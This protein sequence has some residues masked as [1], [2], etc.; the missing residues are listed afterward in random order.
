MQLFLH[1]DIQVQEKHIQC[2]E[3]IKINFQ[4]NR[5]IHKITIFNYK[6][7]T[8]SNKLNNLR[9]LL[10]DELMIYLNKK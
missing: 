8:I 6:K 9:E 5:N 4:I 1:M 10:S 2:K 3:I 7:K